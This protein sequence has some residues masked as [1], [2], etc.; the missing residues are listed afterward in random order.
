MLIVEKYILNINYS[1]HFNI[2]KNV[3]VKV[4]SNYQLIQEIYGKPN[5]ALKLF[6][7]N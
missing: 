5:V 3:H 1:L 7:V 4:L 6:D 2:H